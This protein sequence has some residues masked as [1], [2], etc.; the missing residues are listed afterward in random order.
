MS[1]FAATLIAACAPPPPQSAPPK[2]LPGAQTSRA[3][4]ESAT[5]G[6][7]RQTAIETLCQTL[8]DLDRDGDTR[9]TV[10]DRMLPNCRPGVPCAP[11][12]GGLARYV[13]Q[14]G[15]TPVRLERTH[16]AAQ[17]VQE[18]V[19]ALREEQPFVHVNAARVHADP[20]SYLLHRIHEDFWDELTRRIDVDGRALL[21]AL[22][23]EKVGRGRSTE[24]PWCPA[25]TRADASSPKRAAPANAGDTPSATD[26]DDSLT[27]YLYIP[28]GDQRSMRAFQNAH[29]PKELRVVQLPAVVSN[30]W[31][32]HTTMAHQHGLL[33]LDTDEQLRGK[34]FVV[35]GG[36]FNEM[37]GW[38]SFFISWGLVQS[39][40]HLSLARSMVD[41]HA[42]QIEHYGK[43][44]NANRSY[45]LT[46]SQPP[47][48]TSMIDLVWQRLPDSGASRAWLRRVLGAAIAEYEQVWSASP[49]TTELCEGD[50]CLA[51]YFGE[52]RGQPPEVEPGHFRWFYQNHAIEHGHC[53]A[54]GTE[55]SSQ[56][57]F[58]ACADKLA[59]DYRLD[60]LQDKAID[61]FFA[62]D[63]CV[64]ESGHDTTYR[65]FDDGQERC[66][67][68]ATVDLNALLFKYEIDLARL[69]HS[70]FAGEFGAYTSAGFCK[71]ASGRAAL[72]ERYLWNEQH[73]L[74]FDYDRARKKSS[75]YLSSTTFYPL[76]AS[77]DNPC[78]V[79]LVDHARAER[80]AEAALRQLESAGG[81]M[82]TSPRS[83][84]AIEPPTVW[85][86]D[87]LGA[88]RAQPASGDGGRQWEAPNGWAPHQ[89]LAWAGLQRWGLDT[90]AQR[91]M[92]RWLF[93]IVESAANYHGTVPEK[94]DVVARSHKVFSEYGNVNT[95]FSYIATEGFGW[96]NASFAVGYE[97]LSQPLRAA[98]RGRVPPEDLFEGHSR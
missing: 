87:D 11:P 98:L 76:W 51:R 42:Y 80:L 74:F 69:I 20:A 77:S 37:Y 65:W 24:I 33:M 21:H 97:S 79:A 48:L 27:Y 30:E 13:T 25:Q 5:W 50:V 2:P 28:A 71:R 18:L 14:F 83:L 15:T 72:I 64:R 68:Y 84:S 12:S 34:P 26:Q 96:M 22:S 23:D 73:G 86:R 53:Q 52:G 67:D 95:D 47:F 43:I 59:N 66:A 60:K 16:E 6:A 19:L 78:G 63:R 41:N 92:Y 36:R 38:D 17:F 40:E 90:D 56:T 58:L 93:T 31:M 45:Y 81:L 49:R 82:A 54:P 10:E 44:L 4:G 89:M 1:A 3:A 29:L 9:L 35:P 85:V 61:D 55:P 62:N 91:I 88:V 39:D 46:R 94:F 75:Q 7:P 8:A 57:D 32:A 70:E